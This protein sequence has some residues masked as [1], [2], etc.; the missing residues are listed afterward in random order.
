M[1]A[2]IRYIN[3]ISDICICMICFYVNKTYIYIYIC[4]RANSSSGQILLETGHLTKMCF[5]ESLHEY[6]Y[7]LIR[8]ISLGAFPG[9]SEEM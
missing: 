4:I 3:F 2:L 8:Q 1:Y 9:L 7:L 5:L 6:S